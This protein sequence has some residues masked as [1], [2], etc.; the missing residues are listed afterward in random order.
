MQGKHIAI[1]G[2]DIVSGL[3]DKED[4][5]GKSIKLGNERVQI[6]GVF[7]KEG[8]TLVGDESIDKVV[9]VPAVYGKTFVDLR[10]ANPTIMIKGKDGLPT[11][12]IM[13]EVKMIL[14]SER[15]LKPM[16]VDN[17]ALNQLSQI[18]KRLDSIFG[19]LDLAGIIIGGFSILVGGFGIANI[20]QKNYHLFQ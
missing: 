3:F 11:E 12:E 2:Q 1:V 8:K 9:M 6:I 4:P 17:F 10:R 14:R 18:S 16:E 5:I 19:I 15:R 20:M 7:K 13:D